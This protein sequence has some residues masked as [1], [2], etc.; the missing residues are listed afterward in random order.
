MSDDDWSLDAFVT[1]ALAGFLEAYPGL[2]ARL[3]GMADKAALEQATEGR[4]DD[5]P[6]LDIACINPKMQTCRI[7]VD[8]LAIIAR[9]ARY[10]QAPVSPGAETYT[11]FVVKY[12]LDRY[13]DA[14]AR[15]LARQYFQLREAL[16]DIVP[17]AVFAMSCING[18]PN[19]SYWRVPSTSGSTSPIPPQPRGGGRIAARPPDCTRPAWRIRP[20]GKTLAEGSEPAGHRPVRPRQPG[21]GQP[22]ADPGSSTA[23]TCSFFE[24]TCCTCSAGSRDYELEEKIAVSLRAS[25]AYSRRSWRCPRHPGRRSESTALLPD[26]GVVNRQIEADHVADQ[27][28]VLLAP[29]E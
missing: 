14:D 11:E 15:I 25:G 5:R 29:A 16:G 4:E 3:P 9:C 21:D 1:H 10:A 12:P 27:F 13:S 19:L 20:R 28:D 6:A 7:G 26:G 23:S 18:E 17:E 8:Q 24:K 22:T 2:I